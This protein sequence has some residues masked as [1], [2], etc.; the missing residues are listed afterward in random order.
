MSSVPSLS[1]KAAVEDVGVLVVGSGPIGATFARTIVDAGIKVLIL[2]S[3]HST[4]A[5][6]PSVASG[7]T[8]PCLDRGKW[9]PSAM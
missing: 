8:Q 7:T 3:A 4:T 9:L 6:G 1:E 5:S 2:V